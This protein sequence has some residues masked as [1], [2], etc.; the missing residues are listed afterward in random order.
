MKKTITVILICISL[1]AM[2]QK[3][4]SAS[5]ASVRAKEEPVKVDTVG[6]SII[7]TKDQFDFMEFALTNPKDV[8]PNQIEM[9]IGWIRNKKAMTKPKN[10]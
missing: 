10:K 1:L 4:D 8:T 9:L 7:G 6:Y 3:K 2:A 5:K